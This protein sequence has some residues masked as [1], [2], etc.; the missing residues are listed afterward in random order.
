MPTREQQGP[1]PGPSSL[2]GLGHRRPRRRPTIHAH[3]HLPSSTTSQKMVGGRATERL[4]RL[5]AGVGG[6]ISGPFYP[7]GRC[8]RANCRYHPASGGEPQDET[9]RDGEI[10][11]Q[12]VHRRDSGTLAP[13][14]HSRELVADP[15]CGSR[16]RT[17]RNIEGFSTATPE[18]ASLQSLPMAQGPTAQPCG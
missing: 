6:W 17:C 4:G 7:P 8:A 13:P 12:A 9:L 18:T 15:S 11:E 1:C 10:P 3:S 14:S 5:L 2:E 16:G